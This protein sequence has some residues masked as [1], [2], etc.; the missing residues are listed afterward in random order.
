MDQNFSKRGRRKRGWLVGLI[1]IVLVVAGIVLVVRRRNAA[2]S[3]YVT[4]AVIRGDISQSVEATGTIDAVTTVQVGSQVSGSI[5]KLNADFNSHVH[6]GDLIAEI[7]P[8]VYEGQLL[9]ARA[10]L[11]N[12]KANLATAEANVANAKAKA[13]QAAA[14]YKRTAPL[15]EAGVVSAQQVDAAKAT[16]D[17]A[18]AQVVANEAS[19]KQA[20]AQVSQREAAL[21]VAVTNLAYTKI[22]APIDG[23]VINRAVDLGQT[24]AA[25]FQTPT[26]F[27]IAQDLTK[28]QL[29]VSTD[30]GDV[31]N[32]H[33]GR[34]A[35]F[36]VDAFPGQTF[37]GRIS[38]VRMNATTVQNVVTYET[39][40]D[41]DN[42][43]GKLFPGMTA[44]VSIPV[45]AV[46]GVLKVPN[47]AIRF[48]P[49]KSASEMAELLAGN[50]IKLP[51]GFSGSED[52]STATAAQKES[53]RSLALVWR[54]LPDR[55]LQPVLIRR[56]ITDHSFTAA[57]V[58]QGTLAPGDAVITDEQAPASSGFGPPR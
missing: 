17:S 56:G 10:D 44:Y 22:Y 42:P 14:D 33:V 41:F 36:R 38:Q 46:S 58:V 19:V 51:E 13:V 6:K 7:D 8:R 45:A 29:H 32:I 26:L 49:N 53:T 1:V 5:S 4:N 50:G 28:M 2:A 27:T 25:S 24:V 37:T 12:S 48:K 40:V 30:E 18:D 39:I 34:P 47:T 43:D 9:Q 54:L 55:N 35:S 16:A 52:T 15:G 11:E 57:E 21:E 20:A 3:K 23:I 31:G